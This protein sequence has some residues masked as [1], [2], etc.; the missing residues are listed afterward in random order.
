[1]FSEFVEAQGGEAGR[2]NWAIAV[3]TT[4]QAMFLLVLLLAPLVYTEALPVALLS[5]KAWVAPPMPLVEAPKPVATVIDRKKR[6]GTFID[7]GILI[8]PKGFPP[9]PLVFA[10]PALPPEIPESSADFGVAGLL[11]VLGGGRAEPEPAPVAPVAV[12]RIRQSQI[13]PAMILSQPQPVYPP[14]ARSVGI[15]GDVVLHAIIDREGNIAELQVVSGHPLLVRAALDTVRTW[16]YRPTLLNG[17]PVE[18]DT[19]VTVSFRL[20]R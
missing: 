20:A 2:K 18:V 5:M 10:E 12:Q 6:V 16:R 19:T 14:I 8:Y 7:G 17:E 13:Q 3:S 11:D 15:Q 4:T 9:K 1:M